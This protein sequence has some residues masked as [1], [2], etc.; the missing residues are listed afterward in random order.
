MKCDFP[1]R[2][3]SYLGWYFLELD[4]NA[5]T[6]INSPI[7]LQVQGYSVYYLFICR[8]YTFHMSCHKSVAQSP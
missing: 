6:G 8:L 5:M 7:D 4:R 2:L 3:V 1:V